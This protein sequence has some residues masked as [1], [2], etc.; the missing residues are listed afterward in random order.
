MKK[1]NKSP[2]HVVR[3][4]TKENRRVYATSGR[5]RSVSDRSDG[6]HPQRNDGG[7]RRRC[8]GGGE[9]GK[10]AYVRTSARHARLGEPS[11]RNEATKLRAFG[12]RPISIYIGRG[13]S[14][15]IRMLPAIDGPSGARDRAVEIHVFNR[16]SIHNL[17]RTLR[18]HPGART[19]QS[20]PVNV[21]AVTV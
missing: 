14:P 9:G 12:T 19:P 21:S 10:T 4:F 11:G 17:S 2:S 15:Q 1:F 6:A 8:C 7:R 13:G 3:G 16:P 18:N 20:D 5:V